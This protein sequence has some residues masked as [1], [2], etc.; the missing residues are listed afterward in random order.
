ML[1]GHDFAKVQSKFS[2]RDNQGI[3]IMG[4]SWFSESEK[5]YLAI[6]FVFQN[7]ID[8]VATLQ[9]HVLSFAGKTREAN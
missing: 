6:L 7:A 4:Y 5:T 1:L 3:K 2:K 8:Y 9:K